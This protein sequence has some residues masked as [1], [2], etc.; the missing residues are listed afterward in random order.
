MKMNE[1]KLRDAVGAALLV[2]ALILI[3]SFSEG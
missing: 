3:Y 1:D 2:L